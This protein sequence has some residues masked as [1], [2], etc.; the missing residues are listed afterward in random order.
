MTNIIGL[1]G[2]AEAGKDFAASIID[3]HYDSV[4]KM[5]FAAPIKEACKSLYNLTDSQLHDQKDKIDERWGLSPRQMFQFIGD[6]MREQD[7]NFFTINMKQRM[8]EKFDTKYIVVS[9]VRFDKEAEF[10][11]SLNGKII[12]IIRHDGKTTKY[13]DHVS[14]KGISKHLVDSIISND[15]TSEF[16]NKVIL[17]VNTLFD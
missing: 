13:S 6:V 10:I 4:W 1:T 9:D 11:K 3:N 8:E 14:E 2:I 15:C 5:A 12:K 7:K 17:I 16:E